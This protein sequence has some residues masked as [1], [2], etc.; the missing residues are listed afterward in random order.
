[1]ILANVRT[2]AERR[3]D[4]NAQVAALRIGERRVI[5]MVERYGAAMILAEGFDAILD[6]AERR[7][8]KR[9]TELPEGIY[10]AEDC[11]DE[12]GTVDEPV[13]VRV[14]VTVCKD[15]LSI[16]FAGSAPQ[17]TGNINAVAPMTHSGVFF[18]VKIL[19]DPTIPVNAGTFRPIDVRIPKGSFLDA[20]PPAA[21]CAGNTE[22]THRVAD[23]V[24]KAFAQIAPDRVPAASQGTMNLISSADATRATASST[25]T[26]R[27]SP[28]DRAAGRWAPG[29]T[30]SNAT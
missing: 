24:L 7:M 12:D 8:R 5:E 28:V 1:M 25:P 23:T 10:K 11:L 6:Y 4:L 22:T 19:A 27:R 17:R 2:P 29:R 15:T 18:A 14:A 9:I 30:V 26:S 16:D 3:G 20:Q 13:P 21:V